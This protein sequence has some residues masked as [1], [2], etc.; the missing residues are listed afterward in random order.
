M[1][2]NE[3]RSERHAA[4]DEPSV[5]IAIVT[6]SVVAPSA[7]TTAPAKRL[8]LVVFDGPANLALRDRRDIGVAC[9]A[10]SGRHLSKR[11]RRRGTHQEP[12][13]THG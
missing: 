12:E 4:E 1:S 8:A 3:V 13:D 7:E 9:R 10:L 11:R 6:N 5:G 2:A